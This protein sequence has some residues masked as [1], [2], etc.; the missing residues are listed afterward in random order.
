M[1]NPLLQGAVVVRATESAESPEEIKAVS[2]SF[3]SLS[4]EPLHSAN[5]MS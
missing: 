3:L 1:E 2:L 4:R 5:Y